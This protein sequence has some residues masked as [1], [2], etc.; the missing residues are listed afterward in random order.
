MEDG[1]GNIILVRIE[2]SRNGRPINERS[3]SSPFPLV[4]AGFAGL[5]LECQGRPCGLPL[6]N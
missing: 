1:D 2:Q 5:K 3:E 6:E 4:H